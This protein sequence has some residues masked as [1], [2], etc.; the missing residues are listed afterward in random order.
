MSIFTR[1]GSALFDLLAPLECAACGQPAAHG[2][3]G[4]CRRLLVAA[5]ARDLDGVPV[6]AAAA[7]AAPLD[8]AIQRY[9]YGSRPDLAGALAGL[10]PRAALAGASGDA[11]TLF[12]PVPLHRTRLA[13]RGYDQSALLASAL[14]ARAGRPASARAL[15]RTRSTAQQAR[16]DERGRAQ[17][18]LGAFAA[19][20]G[21]AL[22]ER[23]VVLVDD[24]VTTGATASA[25][26]R[27]LRAAGA[28]VVAVV[29][30]A[31]TPR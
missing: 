18:V 19:G 20:G 3:C 26:V 10:L 12:V 25:C 4:D 31:S 2:Y 14:A 1:A 6:L 7:Y 16:L 22:V 8:A 27:T 11:R 23:P 21:A 30:V 17:N 28:R 5:P 24:V 13:E 29:C 9:K 15:C